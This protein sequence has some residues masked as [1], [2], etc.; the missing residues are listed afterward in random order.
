MLCLTLGADVAMLQTGYTLSALIITNVVVL[1]FVIPLLVRHVLRPLYV[2]A[3]HLSTASDSESV[4]EVTDE[5]DVHIVI[6]SS[7]IQVV[8]LLLFAAATRQASQ[9]A[10]KPVQTSCLAT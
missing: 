4:S 2:R 8:S 10:G 7:L 5:M 1:A 6:G 3:T 9:L